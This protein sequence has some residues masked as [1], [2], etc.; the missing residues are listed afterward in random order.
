MF[1]RG[2]KR[3]IL[4]R[5]STIQKLFH[6]TQHHLSFK[7]FRQPSDETTT[8]LASTG[9]KTIDRLNRQQSTGFQS[10]GLPS[11]VGIHGPHTATGILRILFEGSP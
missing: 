9:F 7:H 3:E 8:A 5:K 4:T 6:Y 10:S 11:Q 2:I 1:R